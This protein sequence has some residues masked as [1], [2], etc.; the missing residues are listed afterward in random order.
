MM[1]IRIRYTLDS[2]ELRRVR[3]KLSNARPGLSLALGIA[4]SA[5]FVLQG[6]INIGF[7][8]GGVF[9]GIG[10]FQLILGLCYI[11]LMRF[12][13]LTN[14]VFGKPGKEIDLTI[15]DF[16]LTIAEPPVRI[17]WRSVSGIRDVGEA[18][19]V[20]RRF[21]RS[22]PI[23]KR[24]LPDGGLDLWATLEAKLTAKRYLIR[25]TDS[26]SLISNSAVR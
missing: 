7:R 3:A 18:Y 26:R 22:I 21:S 2:S 17:S 11:P 1:P 4:L 8:H 6:V 16:G 13:Q 14:L 24:A 12:G 25:G 15:D 20:V 5:G 19:I 9:E 23:L 10:V